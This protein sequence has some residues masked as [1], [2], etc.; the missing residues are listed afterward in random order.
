MP[1]DT[2]PARQAAAGAP[3]E[4]DGPH[5]PARPAA[6]TGP[7]WTRT[8]AAKP[9]H[10][11]LDAIVATTI[12]LADDEGLKAVSVRRVAD[13]LKVRP[14]RLY[15]FF[16]RKDDLIELMVDQVTAEMILDELPADWREALRAIAH[17]A[18]AV[19]E[20]HPWLLASLGQRSGIG[21][22]ATRH[23]EQSLAAVAGLGLSGPRTQAIL[24]AVDAYTV[25]HAAMAFAEHDMR[26]RDL[27]SEAEW[28][29]AIEDYFERMKASNR[30]PHLAALDN[31]YLAQGEGRDA[32]FDAGL[33]WLLEGFAAGLTRS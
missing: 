24:L 32:A 6:G 22:N 33:D 4:D 20:R 27:L 12:A 30:F 1:A 18:R 17:R 31:S 5:R 29:G 3:A 11:T 13:E 14:M 15:K 8:E 25:G 26:Q 21:P 7:V 9:E 28:Q 2:F 23:L 10:L 19:N 16:A